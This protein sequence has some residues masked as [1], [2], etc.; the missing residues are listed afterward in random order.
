MENIIK[1]FFSNGLDDQNQFNS[2][3]GQFNQTN[4]SNSVN[5][6]KNNIPIKSRANDFFIVYRRI[7]SFTLR[8][9]I[10]LI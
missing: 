7:L 5:S 1:K 9:L 3:H 2:Y 6:I 10:E 8:S 4:K